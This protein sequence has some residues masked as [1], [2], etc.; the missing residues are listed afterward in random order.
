MSA[1]C[2]VHCTTARLKVARTSHQGAMP[3]S[4]LMYSETKSLFLVI[5]HWMSFLRT[6]KVWKWNVKHTGSSWTMAPATEL[7][8]NH[9]QPPPKP[10]CVLY[11]KSYPFLVALDWSSASV[12]RS[13]NQHSKVESDIGKG[14]KGIRLASRKAMGS[15][16]HTAAEVG[17]GERAVA[18]DED[19]IAVQDCWLGKEETSLKPL[20]ST[21]ELPNLL[22][23]KRHRTISNR[24]IHSWAQRG[25]TDF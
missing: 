13:E 7:G 15:T 3:G 8:L 22:N 21:F 10:G 11:L 18:Q 17:W 20:Q 2:R 9:F 4:G 24:D 5:C 12:E 1:W 14:W 19:Q 25:T 16:K 23:T 6:L